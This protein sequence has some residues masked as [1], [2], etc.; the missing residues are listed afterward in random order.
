MNKSIKKTSMRVLLLIAAVVMLA[1]SIFLISRKSRVYIPILMYHHLNNEG[2]GDV[3]INTTLFAEHMEA[4]AKNGYNAV[5][6]AELTAYV[7][8]SGSLPENP[9]IITFDDGYLS[10]YETAFPILKQHGLKATV[11]VIG[12]MVGATTYKDTGIW[13]YPCFNYEQAREMYESGVFDIQSHTYDMHQW[14]PNETGDYI[15]ESVLKLDNESEQEHRAALENDFSLSKS[16]IEESVGNQVFVLSY[17]HGDYAAVSEEISAELGF[18]VTVTTKH[19]TNR[20]KIGDEN[21][22]R[23]L[24]RYTITDNISADDLIKLLS[25]F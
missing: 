11:F 16:L 7:D 3:I 1:G 24:N 22:L 5:S 13:T 21:C 23:T 20:I 8:G 25:R 18:T 2:D 10:N 9:V 12:T 15:R 17:P 14:P 19:G 6:F 4:L